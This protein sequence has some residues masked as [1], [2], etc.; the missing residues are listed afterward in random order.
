MEWQRNRKNATIY[1]NTIYNTEN[2][3]CT[4]EQQ[5]MLLLQGETTEAT[6]AA[7]AVKGSYMLTVI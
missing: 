1:A 6:L 7:V 4:S 3:Q 5:M 2:R